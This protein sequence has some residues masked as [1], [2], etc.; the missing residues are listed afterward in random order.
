[1][2]M[3]ILNPYALQSMLLIDIETL[4]VLSNFSLNASKSVAGFGY[5]AMEFPL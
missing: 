5:K 4:E 2:P 3:L 1:M